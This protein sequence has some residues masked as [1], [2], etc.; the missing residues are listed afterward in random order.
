MHGT[1][2]SS[3]FRRLRAKVVA[4]ARPAGWLVLLTACSV[5]PEP[6]PP[7]HTAPAP[8]PSMPAPPRPSTTS[9]LDEYKREIATHIHARNPHWVHE[10]QPEA[11]LRAVVVAR[12]KVDGSGRARA[13]IVRSRDAAMS[14]RVLQSVGAASPFPAPPRRLAGSLATTGYTET[15][16][17]N[18]DGRFQVRTIARPQRDH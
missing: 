17:F 8:T 13:E 9:S 14:E 7:V 12:V 6:A 3:A 4:G 10:E 1:G 2:Q 18:R 5:P 15:W 11:L 16:L